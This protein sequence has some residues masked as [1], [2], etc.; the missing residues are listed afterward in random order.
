[1]GVEEVEEATKNSPTHIQGYDGRFV[2]LGRTGTRILAVVVKRQ[3]QS[4]YLLITARD[5]DK[6]E[7]RKVYEKENR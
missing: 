1:M 6:D 5:A 7:R 4:E 2:V 3:K